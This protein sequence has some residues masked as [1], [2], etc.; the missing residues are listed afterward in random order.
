[1]KHWL[2]SSEIAE[3]GLPDMPATA[4]G[5]QMLA[6]REDWAR[7]SALCRPRA[8]RGGGVEYHVRLLPVG[9]RVAHYR[10]NGGAAL[11]E[12]VAREVQA[13]P[14]P[15]PGT[16]NEAGR[17]LDARI[18]V[19]GALRE[20]QRAAELKQTLA[21][22]YFVDLYN[23]GRADVPEWV[24]EVIQ[25][26]STRSVLR[27]LSASDN[28]ET[29][30]LAVD[31]GA[32][33]RGRGALEAGADGRVKAYTLALVAHNP[34]YTARQIHE[35][36][37]AEFGSHVDVDGE[38]IPL[39][40]QRALE[41]TLK[42]WK[43][44][45]Q[46]ELLALTNPD[47]FVSRT[48]IAGSH[49]HATRLNELWQIDASPVD[50]L[51][52][53]GRH[54]IYLCIDVWSRRLVL[55]V[56]K[57]PRS[58]AV[59]LLMR[60]AI[61]AWGV[62]EAVKTDNGS[63]FVAK[64]TKRLLSHLGIEAITSQAFSPWQKGIIERSVRTFQTDFVRTLPGFIGHSV[65]D[66]KVIEARKAF[67][68]RL[69]T[70]DDKAFA[71]ELTGGE[72]QAFSDR[73]ATE[74][75]G[76]RHHGTIEMSPFA[77]AAS[78]TGTVRRV[79]EQALASLLMQAPDSDGYRIVGKKGVRVDGYH[80][81]APGLIVGERV[82]VRLDPTDK[83]VIWCLGEDQ[84]T[85][86]AK[87]T[88]PELAGV[89]PVELLH[90]VKA[91][92]KRLITERTAE[93][94]A[95]RR[96]ITSRT[97]MDARFTLADKRA[98]NLVAFPPRSEAHST[99]ALETGA[100]IAAMRRGDAPKARPLSEAENRIM[101]ELEA[102]RAAPSAP[103]SNVRRLRQQETPQQLYRK[104]LDLHGRLEAGQPITPDEAAFYGSF[105]NHPAKKSLDPL[106]QEFGEAALR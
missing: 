89:D 44:A 5:V 70:D 67:A 103:P 25:R 105:A 28:G 72:L 104:W 64:A 60:K 27:W 71:V 32:A 1:M 88:C 26:L 91:A 80:Y 31:R 15:A 62:P 100:E 61:V 33:R 43:S 93:I 73:W 3:L 83:G 92:Q 39:P 40:G 34:L 85:V 7:Y 49:D 74:L 36:L 52:V 37:Q 2:T 8:G 53:D 58:E 22:S 11:S 30:R 13:A 55:Y 18:A 68:A 77:R 94:K 98:G 106:F 29:G 50:A 90:E 47:A 95:E 78:W 96:K 56:S 66:R 84:V 17:A 20:F 12:A 76:Q 86:R 23:T 69:G 75:Y 99:P 14:D 82:F 65:A 54:A 81:L 21:V 42:R 9:A 97:V 63:D 59:Q 6:E 16:T 46:T 102:E 19:L 101:A 87:A 57:T 79:D 24:R 4:R 45:H 51:C 38:P 48:R 41:I 35:A 10:A